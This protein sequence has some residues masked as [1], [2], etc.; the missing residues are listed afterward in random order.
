MMGVDTTM[1]LSFDGIVTNAN[2]MATMVTAV[3]CAPFRR[4]MPVTLIPN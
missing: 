3:A 1:R 2:T 4:T